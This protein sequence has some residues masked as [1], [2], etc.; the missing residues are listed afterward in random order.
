ME[1]A[2]DWLQV[3]LLDMERNYDS[4]KTAGVAA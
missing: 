2:V 3:F 1:V 4:L